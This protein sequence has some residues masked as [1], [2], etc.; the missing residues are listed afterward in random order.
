MMLCNKVRQDLDTMLNVTKPLAKPGC[1][2]Y[3]ARFGVSHAR[4]QDG[5]DNLWRDDEQSRRANAVARGRGYSRNRDALRR[6]WRSNHGRSARQRARVLPYGRFYWLH[7]LGTVT[8]IHGAWD[9]SVARRVGTGCV[10]TCRAGW[11]PEPVK[12]TAN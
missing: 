2:F 4:F 3:Y 11:S 10:S 5:H 1:S 6:E 9:R 8:V 12:Q 7:V